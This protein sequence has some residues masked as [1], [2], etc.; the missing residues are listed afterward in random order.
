M[1]PNIANPH[2]EEDLKKRSRY[3]LGFVIV[4]LGI[5]ALRLLY[6]QIIRGQYYEELSKNNRIRI[7]PVLAPRGRILDRNGVVL[8]DNRP[9]LNVV[10]LP[11]DVTD[12]AR[13]ARR[14][15]PLVD[16][17]AKAIEQAVIKGKTRPY[18]PVAVA[19]DVDFEQVAKVE[20]EMF[21]LPGVSIEAVPEREYLFGD[22]ACHVIGYIG[23]VSKARLE[24]MRG[25]DY[26]PGDLVGKNGIEAYCEAALR[27]TKGRRVV[28]VDATG[29]LSSV[30]EEVAPVPGRDVRLTLDADLHA[31]AR[32]SL[33]DRAGAVVAMV[34][35]TGEVLV[36]E[37]TPG[38]E[39]S[40]FAGTLSPTQWREIM[41]DPLHPLENRALRGAYPPGSVYKVVVSLAAFKAGILNPDAR[42][43][44]PGFYS[45]GRV[46]F[47]CWR[48]EG[49]GYVDFVRALTES[50]D[51]YFYN[52]GRALG[53][54]AIAEV[55]TQLGLGRKTGVLYNEAS[56]V[57]PTR[58]WKRKRFGQ[59]WHPGE[60]VIHAIGQGFTAVTPIQVAKAMSAVL[61]GGYVLKPRIVADEPRIVERDLAIP[62]MQVEIIKR[63]LW[64]VVSDPR[65]TAHSIWDKDVPMGGKT[66]TAQV[67]RGYT[68][69]LPDEADIPY[70]YR[71]H[72]WFFGFSPIERPEIVVVAMVEHGGHGGAVAAPIVRDVIKGYYLIKGSRHDQVR[73]DSP[74]P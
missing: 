17:D 6:M 60:S 73:A 71:D 24:E 33:G 57:I 55:A 1:E 30:L 38:Y 59:P 11:E 69:K 42:V 67:A 65:G 41:N 74:T 4:L 37:S 19:R 8:A 15:A 14:L 36:M 31:V 46:S 50:C 34:P 13:T 72:A 25:M 26:S 40:I 62:R 68:S 66:G 64:G 53:V 47:G 45:M 27:G 48:R 58:A 20:M 56:G 51:V 70:R 54:D 3:L 23:E 21:R 18:D 2:L 5:L 9:A 63:G 49:H 39:P 7:L 16:K 52:L 35:D 32:H 29:R 22:L 28:E 43:Y 61:N 44:C 12:V 10:V